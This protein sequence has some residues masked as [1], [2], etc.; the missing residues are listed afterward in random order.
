VAGAARAAFRGF[1]AGAPPLLLRGARVFDG[2][3]DRRADLRLVDGRVAELGR[4]L[5]PRRG[6]RCLSLA[7]HLL[8]PG[9]INAHD[10]LGLDLLPR[11]GEPPWANCYA[12]AEAVQ[13][14]EA[15]PLRELKRVPLRDR[16]LFGAYRNLVSGVTSVAH[17]DPGHPCLGEAGFPV[18]VAN[19][20]A[21]AHSLGISGE[22]AVLRAHRA[23]RRRPFVIHAGEGVDA[24]A[25]D[26]LDR[27]VALGV[28][29]P[30]TLLVHLTA[31][32]RAQLERLGRA[33][34]GAVWCPASARFLYGRAADYG[35][36]KRHLPLALGTDSTLS[37]SAT[38]LDELRVARE[39]GVTDPAELL[40]LVGAGAA[41]LLG[42]RGGEGYLRPGAVADLLAL[43]DPG[44][45]AG[46]ALVR[47]A[48]PD[49]ALVLSQGRPRLA[50]PQVAESLD[51]GPANLRVG[52]RPLWLVGDPAGLLAR[53]AAAAGDPLPWRAAP[54]WRMLEAP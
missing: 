29:G 35:E 25:R 43:P 42:M 31:A 40:A 4:G 23:A 17:H 13:R 28:A 32:T 49:P 54:A 3:V 7:D 48:M 44:G 9:L 26:E 27:L 5:A 45:P 34:V 20:L 38:L 41:R 8:L 1:E 22:S 50:T 30:R 11:L 6:E 18:R 53:I 47:D 16:L 12:W 14:P 10:H 33:G 19:G 36:L 15:S 2:E 21:W 51:L 39:A 52:R 46:E 37:G 24:V